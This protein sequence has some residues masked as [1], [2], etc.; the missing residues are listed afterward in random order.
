MTAQTEFQWFSSLGISVILFLF[1]GLFYVLIGS[2]TPIFMDARIGKPGII[3]SYQTD[4]KLFSG[5]P[6]KIL[7][8]NSDLVKTRRI[9][10]NM[11]AAMLVACGILIIG[12]TWFGLKTGNL[13][14]LILLAI[15]GIVVLPFWWLVFKPYLDAGIKITLADVPPFIWVPGSLFLPA[16]IFGWIGLKS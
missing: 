9:I 11:L 1:Y 8:T 10:L 2:L 15:V 7:D 13:W 4:V 12:V 14:S 6:E 5:E 3:I 16:I